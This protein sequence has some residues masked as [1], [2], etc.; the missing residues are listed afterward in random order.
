M[1]H[2]VC[3]EDAGIAIKSYSPDLIVHPLIKPQ[4]SLN[5][6][7]DDRISALLERVDVV[8]VG[9]GLSRDPLMLGFGQAICQGAMDKQLPLILDGDGIGLLIDCAAYW[10]DVP[11]KRNVIITPNHR[12]MARLCAHYSVPIAARDAARQL[13]QALGNPV[14]LQK[15]IDDLVSNGI[16][17][18]SATHGLPGCPRRCAGQG[19]ILAGCIGAFLAWNTKALESVDPMDSAVL[20][21]RRVRKAAAECYKEYGR[22]ML[23]SDLIN[24][25][26][27][28][29]KHKE[30]K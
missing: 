25:L 21:A 17:M 12:E 23:A 1:A 2:V 15:G 7:L 22:G 9:P 6:D 27:E 4:E 13:S 24:Y 29:P 20:G 8:I 16:R 28:S 10:R 30:K 3:H 14:I 5:S 19:D 26:T 11:R 18:E